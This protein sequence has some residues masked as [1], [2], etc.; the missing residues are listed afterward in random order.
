MGTIKQLTPK[1]TEE[2]FKKLKVRF[3]KNMH[4]HKGVEWLKIQTKL[5]ARNDKLWSLMKWKIQT[6]SRM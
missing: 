5:E 3:E 6:G 4:R 2:L 1:Q